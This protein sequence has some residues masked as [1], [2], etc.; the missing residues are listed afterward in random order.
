VIHSN[1]Q[2]TY[3]DETEKLQDTL[4]KSLVGKGMNQ[5][6]VRISDNLGHTYIKYDPLTD[7]GNTVSSGFPLTTNQDFHNLEPYIKQ[8]I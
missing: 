7:T 8:R 1:R 3:L 5:P 4:R 2:R 6:S